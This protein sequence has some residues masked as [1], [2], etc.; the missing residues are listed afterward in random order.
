MKVLFI[1]GTGT[2]S[3]ACSRLAFERGIEL[4]IPN[5]WATSRSV[6]DGTNEF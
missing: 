3:N 1:G 2:I 6:P 5:R 4:T